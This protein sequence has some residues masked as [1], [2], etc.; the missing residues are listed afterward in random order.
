MIEIFG[1]LTVLGTDTNAMLASAGIVS[2][3][4]GLGA[5][6]LI[7][8]ILAGLFIIFEGDFRVGDIITEKSNYRGRVQEIGIRS[9]KLLDDGQNVKIMLYYGRS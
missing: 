6:P 4:I 8:D 7:S 3:V 5:R 2:L 9:T 1:T